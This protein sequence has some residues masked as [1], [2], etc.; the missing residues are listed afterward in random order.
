MRN[1]TGSA[2]SGKTKTRLQVLA[3]ALVFFVLHAS[4]TYASR[5][6]PSVT[7]V[8]CID[9][10]HY[11]KRRLK[12]DWNPALKLRHAILRTGVA[13]NIIEEAKLPGKFG[14]SRRVF[15]KKDPNQPWER[16]FDTPGFNDVLV[17]PDAIIHILGSENA[18]K[19]G[20]Q[21]SPNQV[22]LPD[23]DELRGAINNFNQQ[24]PPGDSRRL[25]GSFFAT[26]NKPLSGAEYRNR[27]LDNG[28]LPMARSGRLHFHDFSAH[29]GFIF[30]PKE[31]LDETK[32]RIRTFWEF[33]QYLKKQD[34]ALSRL[35]S[36][37]YQNRVDNL[38]DTHSNQ[39]QN[40]LIELADGGFHFYLEMHQ[41][42]N[43]L[44][45]MSA[46]DDVSGALLEILHHVKLRPQQVDALKDHVQRFMADR[47]KQDPEIARIPFGV[48]TSGLVDKDA[49]EV[50]RAR[51][52]ELLRQRVHELRTTFQNWNPSP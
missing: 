6:A 16:Y 13:D 8:S 38:I 37:M 28:E 7:H 5:E 18:R 21:L 43:N 46:K 40:N 9:Y 1:L 2:Y 10:F 15:A 12:F 50:I 11:L 34:P 26:D 3:W 22:I 42:S 39:G 45:A 23:V 48:T 47:I 4:I 25:Q 27:F 19:L 20:F 24:F 17:N 49:R 35:V 52:R 14:G 31:I 36:D 51:T 44:Y 41:L 33:D 30:M 32:L 29:I